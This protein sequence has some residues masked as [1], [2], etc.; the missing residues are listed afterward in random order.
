MLDRVGRFVSHF[1]LTLY[2]LH[3][4]VKA[5]IEYLTWSVFGIGQLSQPIYPRYLVYASMHRV[6]VVGAYR[7]R[8]PFRHALY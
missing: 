1:S 5:V 7:F 4:P 3:V 6:L 2:V 8:L